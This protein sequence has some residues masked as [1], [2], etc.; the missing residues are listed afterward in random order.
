[1]SLVSIVS[2][3]GSLCLMVAFL[4]F[5]LRI[6]VLSIRSFHVPSA[7]YREVFEADACRE[8]TT[9]QSLVSFACDARTSDNHTCTGTGRLASIVQEARGKGLCTRHPAMARQVFLF[10]AFC[11]VRKHCSPCF[12]SQPKAVIVQ[13]QKSHPVHIRNDDC[14]NRKKVRKSAIRLFMEHSSQ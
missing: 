11:S 2:G 4:C 12:P 8:V 10:A 6:F 9:N 1:M 7:L 5:S 14:A 13:I 3:S